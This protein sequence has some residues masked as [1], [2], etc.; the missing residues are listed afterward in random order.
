M[1]PYGHP[2]PEPTVGRD[3]HLCRSCRQP[4]VVPVSILDA[5]DDGRFLVELACN[6]C[7]AASLRTHDDASLEE[8]DIELDRGLLVIQEALDAIVLADELERIDR[9]A[10]AL[11]DDKIL[12]EDF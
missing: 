7:G 2:F 6:N 11:H 12:P 3:L 10:A 9:F 5:Y 8:L 1:T 4:F